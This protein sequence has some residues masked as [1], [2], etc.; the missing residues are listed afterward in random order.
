MKHTLK[1]ITA[2]VLMLVMSACVFGCAKNVDKTITVYNASS[3]FLT[4]LELS[5]SEDF[6]DE[7]STITIFDSVN[8]M[9]MG[10]SSDLV[11]KIPEKMLEGELFVY[12]KGVDT[13]TY[14]SFD[15]IEP[16]GTALNEDGW[17]FL[18]DFDKTAKEFIV[19]VLD[20]SDI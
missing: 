1:R 10:Q 8:I 20:D 18:I 5:A 3:L 16:I 4:A 11:V 2:I 15:R 9:Q 14:E 19:T 17:G 6:S 12:V 13:E 7:D